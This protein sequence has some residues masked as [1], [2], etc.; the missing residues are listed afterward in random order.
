MYLKLTGSRK[1]SRLNNSRRLLLSGVPVNK[2]LWTVLS[3]FNRLKIRLLSDFTTSSAH[4]LGGRQLTSLTFIDDQHLPSR[5]IPEHREFAAGD[6]V[7]CRED[8]M[9][10]RQPEY[11]ICRHTLS[12]LLLCLVDLSDRAH[13]WRSL[14]GLRSAVDLAW[15][16]LNPQADRP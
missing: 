14:F 1:L 4:S 2:I 7:V 11:E 15:R 12:I 10:D 13:I 6:Q 3:V 5:Y 8:H 16:V 9:S